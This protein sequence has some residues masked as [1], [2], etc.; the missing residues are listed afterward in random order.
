M[1]FLKY[2]DL[3]SNQIE[4]VPAEIGNIQTL[5]NINLSSNKLLTIQPSFAKIINLNI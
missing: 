3:H 2:L 1:K 4:W 5:E